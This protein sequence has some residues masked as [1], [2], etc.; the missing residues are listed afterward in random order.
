MSS[1]RSSGKYD[2]RASGVRAETKSLTYYEDPG[3]EFGDSQPY[4]AGRL[5]SFVHEVD[6]R[7]SCDTPSAI[8]NV[9]FWVARAY[10]TS[11]VLLLDGR[12]VHLSS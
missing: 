1:A 3:D 7:F 9:S 5:M 6:T 2:V 4:A 12:H 11:L 8:G 10:F